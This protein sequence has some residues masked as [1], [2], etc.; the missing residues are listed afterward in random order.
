MVLTK[1]L[2]LRIYE[3]QEDSL[4]KGL[5]R[6]QYEYLVSKIG[7]LDVFIPASLRGSNGTRVM[8]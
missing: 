2:F 3:Q 7:G 8:T 6:S 4:T 1:P 5:I